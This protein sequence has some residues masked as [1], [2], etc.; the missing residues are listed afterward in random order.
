MLAEKGLI[1]IELGG[2]GGVAALKC[3]CR[4]AALEVVARA[5][6]ESR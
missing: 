2:G 4:Y 5:V 6:V 1:E 3:H